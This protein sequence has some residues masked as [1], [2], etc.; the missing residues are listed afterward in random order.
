MGQQLVHESNSTIKHRKGDLDRGNLVVPRAMD[1]LDFSFYYKPDKQ[2]IDIG[3][4][5]GPRDCHI[6]YAKSHWIV[7]GPKEV[8][9]I[10]SG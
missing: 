3:C 6:I 2:V 8:G 9:S 4:K 1:R 10:L 5:R 7:H